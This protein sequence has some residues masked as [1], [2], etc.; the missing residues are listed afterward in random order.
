VTRWMV[1]LTTFA[2]FAGFDFCELGSEKY[3]CARAGY[4]D[5]RWNVD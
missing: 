5:P 3:T 4:G 2:E 1:R